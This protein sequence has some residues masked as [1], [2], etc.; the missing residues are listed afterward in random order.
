[1]SCC[2]LIIEIWNRQRLSDKSASPSWASLEVWCIREWQFPF[3]PIFIQN[4]SLWLVPQG[5]CYCLWLPPVGPTNQRPAFLGEL[6]ESGIAVI[7][8]HTK[9]AITSNVSDES[10]RVK[11]LRVKHLYSLKNYNVAVLAESIFESKFC[12]FRKSSQPALEHRVQSGM[13]L[14]LARGRQASYN[15]AIFLVSLGSSSHCPKI[16]KEIWCYDISLQLRT[17]SS[18]FS[19]CFRSACFAACCLCAGVSSLIFCAWVDGPLWFAPWT[20]ADDEGVEFRALVLIRLTRFA[21]RF[22]GPRDFAS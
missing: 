10:S 6:S 14:E 15:N 1:M 19:S 16:L 7:L 2:S 4:P 12:N 22:G 21:G 17:C 8:Y 5:S 3:H 13:R 9:P 20:V 18:V 11:P